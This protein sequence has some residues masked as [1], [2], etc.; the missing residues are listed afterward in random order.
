MFFAPTLLSLKEKNDV[1]VLCLSSGNEKGLGE[2]RRKELVKSC[3][4]LGIDEFLV[5]VEEHP[6][7]QD[8]PSEIWNSDVI[9]NILKEYIEKNSIDTIITFDDRGI[10]G[11]L[12]HISAFN[13]AK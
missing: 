3:Q 12:N 5:D 4:V 7:L 8:N 2:V 10:S 9:F 11:H 13:G 6:S 1:M